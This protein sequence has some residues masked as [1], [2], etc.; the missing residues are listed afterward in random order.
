M[1]C[2]TAAWLAWSMCALSLVLTG[3]GL[4]FHILNLSQPSVPTLTY[5]VESTVMG[6]V[7]AA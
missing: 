7:S 4:L 1:S 2:R 6:V 5:W 3:L